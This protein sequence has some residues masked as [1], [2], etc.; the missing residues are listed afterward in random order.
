MP[1]SFQFS[2]L[3]SLSTICTC[4][5]VG[6]S[7]EALRLCSSSSQRKRRWITASKTRRA[8]FWYID[9]PLSLPP[10]F[11]LTFFFPSF[12]PSTTF[13]HVHT[14]IH[15]YILVYNADYQHACPFLAPSLIDTNVVGM[16]AYFHSII[17]CFLSSSSFFLH[18]FCHFPSY[19]YAFSQF[20]RSLRYHSLQ[21][22]SSPL[23][24][25]QV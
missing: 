20:R 8:A 21:L 12:P 6:E 25:Y 17:Y 23:R 16:S 9:I 22:I 10:L 3:F 4:L 7:Q 2:S 5:K 15:A 18:F 14:H 11:L 1:S 24:P 13:S 19:Y